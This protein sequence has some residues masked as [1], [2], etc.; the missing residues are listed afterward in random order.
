MFDPVLNGQTPTM[1]KLKPS[2]QTLHYTQ[3]LVYALVP[4]PLQEYSKFL[5]DKKALIT[6]IF[7]QYDETTKT[8]IVLR[9]TYAAD[10]QARRLIEF[11]NRLHTVCFG[12]DDG[13]LSYAPYKQVV[14]V[15]LLNNFSNSNRMTLMDSKKKSRLNMIP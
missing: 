5:A 3:L 14:V 4:S 13:G 2:T 6:I 8:K 11:L 9:A 15:K 1:W 10:R 12:S 7:G